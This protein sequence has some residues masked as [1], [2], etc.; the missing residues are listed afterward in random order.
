MVGEYNIDSNSLFQQTFSEMKKLH[1]SFTDMVRNADLFYNANE[2]IEKSLLQDLI[3]ALDSYAIE[4]FKLEESLM[5]QFD[6]PDI[7]DMI[8]EHLFF[9]LKV[10]SFKRDRSFNPK[11]M[12][13]QVLVFMKKWELC[14][15]QFADAAFF[16]YVKGSYSK[17][18]RLK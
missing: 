2:T 11:M 1:F 13:Y 16:Q 17:H 15:N 10:N 4:L 8:R 7:Y 9:V 18:V 6:Y 14:H 12:F 5:E 3:C